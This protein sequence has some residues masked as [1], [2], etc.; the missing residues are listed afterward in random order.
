MTG[1]D[2]TAPEDA[3]LRQ[4]WDQGLSGRE[5]GLAMGK[6]KNS[7]VGR[8]HRLKLP[9]RPSPIR[10]AGSARVTSS[11]P[12]RGSSRPGRV[13]PSDPAADSGQS[14]A[15]G[16]G[17]SAADPARVAPSVPKP[18]SGRLSGSAAPMRASGIH[19]TCQYIAG[20]A[21]GAETVFCGK[22]VGQRL[23][24]SRSSYCPAHHARCLDRRAIFQPAKVA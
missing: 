23:D 2:W 7:V 18:A 21:R 22:P 13:A 5:I 10:E 1:I 12:A 17:P 4:L 15:T 3:R 8:V 11:P 9:P 14:P 6:T 20:E 24:G 19:L 16:R